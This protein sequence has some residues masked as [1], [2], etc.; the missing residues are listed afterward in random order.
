[1]IRRRKAWQKG[2][3]DYL[4]ADNF[5]TFIGPVLVSVPVDRRLAWERGDIDYLG[6]DSYE[7]LIEQLLHDTLHMHTMDDDEN[8]DEMD[9]DIESS[10]WH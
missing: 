1:M 2:D 8:D 5:E 6:E 3:I 7:I 9:D 10:D 4:G